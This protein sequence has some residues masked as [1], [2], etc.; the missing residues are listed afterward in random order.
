[1][2]V[3][4]L[5][6]GLIILIIVIS[7]LTN[8]TQKDYLLFNNEL[9][10][11]QVPTNVDIER[12]NFFLFS[13]YAPMSSMGDYGIVHLGFMGKFHQISEGQYDYPWWLE[14]FN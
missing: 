10:R 2:K 3:S 9:T 11:T 7:I 4:Y 1:M 5:F 13:T 6:T 8:P 14:P 12:I